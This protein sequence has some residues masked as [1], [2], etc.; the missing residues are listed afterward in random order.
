MQI[1]NN[2]K[3]IIHLYT[4][5]WNEERMLSFF[6]NH[7]DKFV[8]KYIFFNDESNDRTIEIINQHPNTE[9]RPFPNSHR[10]SFVLSAQS[11]HNNCW[12]ESRGVSD[13]VIVT[14]VD[15][16]L[17]HPN[18]INFLIKCKSENISAIP[19][20]GYQM[21]TEIFPE[22]NSDLTI[23]VPHG[24]VYHLMNKLSMF[25]PNKIKE[26][27]YNLGRHQAA[28]EGQIKYPKQDELLNLHFK[29]LSFNF[30]HERHRQLLDK[31]RFSDVKNK[32]GV[33]Y[34]FNEEQL[35]DEWAKTK[36]A[37]IRN[38]IKQWENTTGYYSPQ[39]E[40]WWKQK[41]KT[42]LLFWR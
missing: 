39:S 15:E 30:L 40:R 28:P 36:K 33:Q 5:C 23:E 27:N 11:V 37:L 35:K 13:W 16:F 32:W 17:Y 3:P 2:K 20:L 34:T 9:V 21:L 6:F 18:I 41:E 14:A 42:H 12:K 38:V 4:I 10:D 19:A 7:Y 25:D 29:Y 22:D 8:D 24:A 1:F 26:T 31:L